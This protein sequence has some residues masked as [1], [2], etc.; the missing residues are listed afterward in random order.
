MWNIFF[1]VLMLLLQFGK[2][3]W[4]LIRFG[5]LG[6]WAGRAFFFFFCGTNILLVDP[7]G[8][9]C[10][11]CFFSWVIGGM[12]MYLPAD[13]GRSPLCLLPLTRMG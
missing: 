7:D 11:L 12:A 2:T 10:P 4:L 8:G 13:P 6:H 9:S 1:G 3:E 5:F